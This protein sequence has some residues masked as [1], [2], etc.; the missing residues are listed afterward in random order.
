MDDRLAHDLGERLRFYRLAARK[1]QPVVAGLAGI[2]ADYLYQIERGKKVPTLQVAMALARVLRIPIGALVGDAGSSAM[3]EQPPAALGLALHRA[4]VIPA[5]DGDEPIP[6]ID[7]RRQVSEAW[8]VWQTCPNRY[9]RVATVLPDLVREVEARLHAEPT[10]VDYRSAADLYG[11]VRTVAKRSGRVDAA[12]IAADRSYRAAEAAA[13][14]V[15][16][17]AA[18]WNLAHAALAE[19]QPDLAEDIA[20]TAAESVRPTTGADAAAIHGSLMLVAAVAA[21]RRGDPWAGRDRIRLTAPVA[22]QTGERNVLWTAFGPTNVAMHLVSVEAE[23]G[24]ALEAAHVAAKVSYMRSPSIERRV[25][26]LLD[27]ARSEQMRRDY[28][29]VFAL[30]STAAQEAPEDVA[31]R[32]RGRELLRSVIQH[33]GRSTAADAVQLANRLGVSPD[34]S[35]GG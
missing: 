11:L 13:D 20:V 28:R 1:T 14:P 3:I 12:A 6:P 31:R 29:A 26:F 21:A 33:A 17:G 2:T 16:I 5:G 4:M 30:L 10:V 19:D 15:R 22:R 34:A 18:R 9:T 27:E 32:P 8:R 35:P 23:A 24:E 25:A 7:L